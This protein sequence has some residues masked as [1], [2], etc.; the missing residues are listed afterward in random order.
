MRR[1][2]FLDRD[3]VLNHL[4]LRPETGERDGPL[5]AE[6]MEAMAGCGRWLAAARDAG[7]L[8]VV[9]TNQPAYAKGKTTRERLESAQA[10][11]ERQLEAQGVT[12]DGVYSCYHHPTESKVPELACE[13]E[14]RKPKPGLIQQAADELGIDVSRSWMIG[15]RQSDILAGKAAGCRTIYVEGGQGPSAPEADF[16]CSSL[17]SAVQTILSEGEAQ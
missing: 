8:L 16:Q 5:G 9:I 6:E 2:C 4:V 13:C 1:A 11:L 15:D 7:Y 12:L 14:C 17:G 10:K 3:G